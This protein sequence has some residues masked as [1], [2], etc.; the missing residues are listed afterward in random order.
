M[1]ARNVGQFLFRDVNLGLRKVGEAPGM[2]GIAVRQ[3]DVPH[4]FSI[5][6]K[7]FNP[8]NGSVRLVELET[9]H[10]NERLA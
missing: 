1:T 6:S 8:A 5:E 9:R 2:I 4:V 7:S 10:V 3:D